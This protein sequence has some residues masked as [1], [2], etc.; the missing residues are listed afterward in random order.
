MAVAVA[1]GGS[2]RRPSRCESRSRRWD[3]AENV[4]QERDAHLTVFGQLVADDLDPGETPDVVQD[5]AARAV[6]Q[7][8]DGHDDL[9]RLQNVEGVPDAARVTHARLA[10]DPVADCEQMVTGTFLLIRALI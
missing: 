10:H 7:V 4:A 2:R 9:D 1:V 5:V 6:R 3:G 8:P